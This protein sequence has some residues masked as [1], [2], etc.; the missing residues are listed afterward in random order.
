M[1]FQAPITV[2][3]AIQKIHNKSYLLPA[4]QRELVWEAEQIE[5]LFDSIM[6]GY[7]IGSFLFWKVSKEKIKEYQFYEFLREYHERDKR[8][9]PKAD[10]SG[11]NEIT[12]ILDGQQRLT[13]LY[14]GLKGTY[15]YKLPY[16]R[17]DRNDAFP[18][19]ELYLNLLSESK[20][21]DSKYDFRFLTK[22]EADKNDENIFWFSVGKILDFD[23]DN[24]AEFFNYLVE[25]NLS[26]S[27]FAGECI[28]KLAQV[29]NKEAIINYYLEE[30]QILD[31]VLN[32]FIRV[33]SGGTQLSYSD[34]LLSIATAQ[35]R[36]KDA[37]EEIVNFVDDI[38]KIGDGFFFNKDFVL[39]TCLVLL[40]LPEIAFK[41]DN[42]NAINMRK[43]EESWDCITKAIK[44]AVNLVYSFGYN[45][46]TLT[47]NYAIIPIAYYILKIDNPENYVLSSKYN[48][49]RKLIRDWLSK[50]LLKKIFGGHPD[51]VL[52]PIREV[53]KNS[54]NGFSYTSIIEKLRGTAKSL[55]FTED[56]IKNLLFYKCGQ[57]YTF[58]V[59][60]LIYPTLDY[61]NK[62]HQDHIF[63]K[64][65]FT[66][67]NK[68][69]RKGIP[70]NKH[71][72]YLKNYNY[73]GN[74]QLLEGLPNE[75]KSNKDF[76][77][78]LNF[79][80]PDEQLRKDYHRKHMIPDV[81]LD[82]KNFEEFFNKRNELIFNKLKYL[83]LDDKGN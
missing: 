69:I 64:S 71:E 56:E 13:A 72:F 31:K 33:N 37:R 10:I 5:K 17:W 83:I 70:E 7:P 81:D 74:L 19:R 62:F 80:F 58:S 54:T 21:Y 15:A 30:D 78:W 66:S 68:L 11:E 20:D 77:E 38:N 67:R 2:R 34:L 40:D 39:K 46:Q 27:K 22:K 29:I 49:D 25:Q 41:V 43:I 50:A 18:K 23:P 12:A 59:L 36:E 51:S 1:A 4:I 28:F 45:Y 73:I 53:I 6:R 14:I 48:N 57:G 76:K 65:F 8:H 47:S 79:T 26:G 60:S 63:P 9:N 32:I 3:T 55:L 52:K 16:K 24:P 44:K 61:R 35:W 42:F 75:E 82:F